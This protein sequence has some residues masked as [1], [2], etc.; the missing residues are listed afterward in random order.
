[1]VWG[2]WRPSGACSESEFHP[3]HF[4]PLKCFFILNP[5][6]AAPVPVAQTIVFC[7][8]RGCAAAGC[9]NDRAHPQVSCGA[10]GSPCEQ[11]CDPG[12]TALRSAAFSIIRL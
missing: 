10:V 8:L 6:V 9:P 1:M 2:I 12:K 11:T 4:P 3:T 5:A 7:G